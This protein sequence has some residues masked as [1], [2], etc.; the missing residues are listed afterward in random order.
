MKSCKSAHRC[1][2]RLCYPTIISVLSAIAT[3]A[4]WNVDN[5]VDAHKHEASSMVLDSISRDTQRLYSR[6]S[7]V[8][9]YTTSFYAVFDRTRCRR[10]ILVVFV[11]FDSGEAGIPVAGN[12]QTCPIWCQGKGNWD[13]QSSAYESIGSPVISWNN[14]GKA[15]IRKKFKRFSH[16]FDPKSLP[17]TAVRGRRSFP[18][19]GCLL[20][21]K[22]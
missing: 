7:T 12:G 18:E 1:E 19:V 3:V 2:A 17:N 8:V 15:I 9:V 5:Q 11:G 13:M 16:E 4:N 6:N 10:C 22:L 14:W 20:P 21:A